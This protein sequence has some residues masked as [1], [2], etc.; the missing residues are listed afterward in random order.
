[1]KETEYWHRTDRFERKLELL[2]QAWAKR[3]FRLA[4]ALAASIRDTLVFAQQEEESLGTPHLRAEDFLAVSQL[5][6]P[7]RRW[8]QPWRWAKVLA[9]D[10]TVALE[11]K[12]EPV[13]LVAAFRADQTASLAR[14][15]RLARIEPRSGVLREIPCQVTEEQRRGDERSCRL[16]F[17]ADAP[18]HT[19]TLYLVLYGNP[20]AEL[21]DYSTDLTVSGEGYALQIENDYYRATLSPQMGQL[22]RLKIKR[23]HGQELFAGGEGHGEPPCIDW[24][25]DYVTSNNFQKMRLTNWAA[26]PDSEVI[27]G[28]VCVTVRRWGFP[29]S[30]VHPV[31]T[32]SRLHI[33]VEYRFV[34]GAPYFFKHGVMEVL[35]ELEVGYL[36]DDEWVFSGYSFTD[37]VWMREDGKLRVGPVEPEAQENLWA[38][39]FFHRV[40]RDAFIGLFLEHSAEGVQGL[41]HTGAP[42]LHYRWHGPVWSRALFH[43]SVLPAGARLRQKNAYLV[44]PFAEDGGAER[45]ERIRHQLMH[46]L[47]AAPAELP[48]AVR[49]EAPPGRLARPGEAGDSP[50]DKRVLWEALADCR[51]EQLYTANLSVVDLG[52]IYDL[53]VRGQTVEVILTTPHRGRP[54]YGYYVWGSGGNSQPIRDRLRKVPG[55]ERV[56][57]K[58]TWDP[59]WNSNRLSDAGRRALGLGSSQGRNVGKARY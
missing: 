29:H 56:V 7:W 43:N 55:V 17:L 28:P 3:D 46:P 24:A 40:S 58:P 13:E 25:H 39:G 22:E 20:D 34:A 45:V 59:P 31:F 53:R 10:E 51:D 49:A 41:R 35:Q 37:T 50:I 36:R 30:P 19:R 27:R 42:M 33:F 57:V 2:E 52:L 48:R 15:V 11:R 18:A 38:V 4:R 32:P 8:A 5:P 16:T 9:L 23:E 14:E 12:G 47:A 54:R 21:P 44:L 1:M 26:C 6:E